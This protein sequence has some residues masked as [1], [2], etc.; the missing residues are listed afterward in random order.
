MY[1]GNTI[2]PP[3][4]PEL[5]PAEERRLFRLYRKTKDAKAKDLLVRRYLCWAFSIATKLKGPRL[6]HDD[7]ISAANEGLVVAIDKFKPGLNN[8][9]TTY[10]Y[11][12]VRR[13]VIE[14]LLATYPVTVSAHLRKKLKKVDK[15]DGHLTEKGDP[16]TLEEL[17]ERL[18]QSVEYDAQQVSSFKQLLWSERDKLP[19]ELDHPNKAKAVAGEK[20]FEE[21]P[22][23]AVDR[24][25][26]SAEVRNFIDNGEF[27]D[28][29]REVLLARHY[30]EPVESF[31]SVSIRLHVAKKRIRLSYESAL[32]KLKTRFNPNAEAEA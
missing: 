6:S 31:E 25:D 22:A 8:R 16:R 30:R 9:F 21:S 26:E 23:E 18:G 7:A 2:N 10:A 24:A 27:S 15:P 14:A 4:M 17:F 3:D 20:D 11:L 28:L 12:V 32:V 5:S 13:H 19:E 1:Y 29:E